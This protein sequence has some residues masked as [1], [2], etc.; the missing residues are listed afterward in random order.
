[1]VK[2][3]GFEASLFKSMPQCEVKNSFTEKCKRLNSPRMTGVDNGDEVWTMLH[4]ALILDHTGINLD[5]T[6]EFL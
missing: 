5:L 2:G 1:M 4:E 6:L 3:Y